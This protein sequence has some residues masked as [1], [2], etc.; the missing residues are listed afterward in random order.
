MTA[1]VAAVTSATVSVEKKAEASTTSGEICL[2]FAR[3]GGIDIEEA[4]AVDASNLESIAVDI[5]N[6]PDPAELQGCFDRLGS[7]SRLHAAYAEIAERLYGICVACDATLI[8]INPII[9]CDNS[10]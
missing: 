8:E 5:L 9:E 1:V 10:L 6:G 7:E 4:T 3:D 2:L